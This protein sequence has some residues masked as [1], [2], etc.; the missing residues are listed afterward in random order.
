MKLFRGVWFK[1]KNSTH[2]DI[3]TSNDEIIVKVRST[4]QKF[5]RLGSSRPRKTLYNFL[6][7]ELDIK[8]SS[9]SFDILGK[10]EHPRFECTNKNEFY[11][12]TYR[13]IMQIKAKQSIT[14]QRII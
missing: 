8:L 13:V 10:K 3:L 5:C 2:D 12:E 7:K 6:E 11:K 9:P 14:G 4:I 1:D